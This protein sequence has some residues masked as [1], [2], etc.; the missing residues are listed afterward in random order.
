VLRRSLESAP[1]RWGHFR[2]PKPRC[3]FPEEYAL[4]N[5]VQ[6]PRNVY[7]RENWLTEPLD[8]WLAQA[9]APHRLADTINAMAAAD[10]DE[11]SDAAAR[12]TRRTLAECDTKLARYRAALD[13]GAD[14]CV[15]TAWIAQTQAERVKAEADLR[16]STGRSWMSRDEIA[17]MVAV[18]G[19][20]VAVL[21]E[22]DSADKAEL[23]RQLGIRLTY[24]PGN[25]Q[26]RAEARLDPHY[27]EMVSVRGGRRPIRQ[28]PRRR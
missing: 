21:R 5:R 9:F 2:P 27:G 26:V 16:T 7:L 14:P 13:T 25:N 10:R 12:A 17:R 15:V 20:L 22:A 19:D 24:H 3:R 18:L 23:Y 4:A 28:Q 11:G 1:S 6:H 8:A